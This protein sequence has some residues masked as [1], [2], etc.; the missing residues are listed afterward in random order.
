MSGVSSFPPL[1]MDVLDEVDEIDEE[2]DEMDDVGDEGRS[3]LGLVPAGSRRPLD[4]APGE[5]VVR[6]TCGR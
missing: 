4:W 6:G 2:I 3:R 1:V 5:G